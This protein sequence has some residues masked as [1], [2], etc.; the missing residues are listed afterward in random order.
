MFFL[1]YFGEA[2]VGLEDKAEWETDH[3][4]PICQTNEWYKY[5]TNC[6][7]HVKNPRK[8]PLYPQPS[9]L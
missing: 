5:Y 7:N 9:I 4:K 2:A 1:F 8:C 6:L 3:G